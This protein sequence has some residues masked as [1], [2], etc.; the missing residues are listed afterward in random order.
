VKIPIPYREKTITLTIPGHHSVTVL[1][2]RRVKRGETQPMLQQS[3]KSAHGSRSFRDFLDTDEKILCVVNDATR[4]TPT[5]EILSYL[6]DYLP[7]LLVAF[8]VATGTHRPPS[9]DEM[10]Q[11]FGPGLDALRERILIHRCRDEASLFFAGRTSFGNEI[12][13][14]RALREFSKV[15]I[16]TSVEPHYFAG[17]TGGRKSLNP[18]L[19]GEM[20]VVFNHGLALSPQAE[21]CA[22]DDNPVHMDIME[23][24][25]FL[26]NDIFAIETVLDRDHSIYSIEAGDLFLS[27]DAAVAKA[28]EVFCIDIGERYDIVITVTTFPLDIDLYQSQKSIE[29]GRLALKEGGIL[30]FVSAC[31]K[32]TGPRDYMDIMTSAGNV[33]DTLKI[34]SEG[35]RFG[36]HKAGKLAQM[37]KWAEIWGVTDL[38]G[39]ILSSIFIRPF[40]SV[41]EAV[42]C[43]LQKK[44]RSATVCVLLDGSHLVPRL[45]KSGQMITAA[46]HQKR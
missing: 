8:I 36:Y 28:D 42:S 3:L 1:E 41:Q 31:R 11:I 26:H 25:S 44:G 30:I 38:D 18:G 40:S 15:L 5:A 46:L 4:P 45:K 14:N 7:G 10:V 12:Y 13:F 16:I 37:M 32:G 6:E 17:Y 29:N 43:A 39:E 35:Y 33:D 19:A 9:E 23:S 22:L 20:T 2:P 21:A 24:M 34:V 27:F